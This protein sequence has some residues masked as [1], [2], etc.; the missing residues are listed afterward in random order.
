MKRLM[1]ICWAVASLFPTIGNC[2]DYALAYRPG[3]T[4][5]DPTPWPSMPL[6]LYTNSTSWLTGTASDTHFVDFSPSRSDVEMV[7][8]NCLDFDGTDDK[9]TSYGGVTGGLFTVYYLGT[10]DGLSSYSALMAQNISGTTSGIDWMLYPKSGALRFFI[11]NGS[12]VELVESLPFTNDGL[13]HEVIGVYGATHLKLYVDG[14]EYTTMR[15][16]DCQFHTTTLTF[17]T[18][19]S[20]TFAQTRA[21]QAVIS[22]REVSASEIA[23]G[24]N[25]SDESSFVSYYNFAEGSGTTVYDTS[26]NGNNGIISGATWAKQDVYHANMVNGHARYT[27][28]VDVVYVPMLADG[29]GYAT[30]AVSGYALE[31]EYP[32]IGSGVLHNNAETALDFGTTTNTY[33]NLLT[34]T[35]FT[36]TTNAAGLITELI[37]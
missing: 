4:V 37:K 19:S 1:V 36:V 6:S 15:T 12:S 18:Y 17:G 34:N 10:F 27:N 29:S 33:A 9:V 25:P 20:S 26:G 23:D 24:W 11:S 8:S 16:I 30:N 31:G 14:V 2:N 22:P 5:E 35:L 21:I 3:I 13:V 7:Q 32:P 28:G